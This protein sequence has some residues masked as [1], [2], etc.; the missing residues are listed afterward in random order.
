MYFLL[1]D[2]LLSSEQ[3][4]WCGCWCE[5]DVHAPNSFS[6]QVVACRAGCV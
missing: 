1:M 3:R 5:C 2:S 6:C 4:M